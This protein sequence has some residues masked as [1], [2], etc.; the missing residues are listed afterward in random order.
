MNNPEKQLW[1]AKLRG[2]WQRNLPIEK[3]LPDTQPAYVSSWIYTFGV[4]TLQILVPY[5]L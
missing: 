5:L 2:A 4:L 1:T 3:L